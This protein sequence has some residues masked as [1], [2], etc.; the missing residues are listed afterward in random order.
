MIFKK[1]YLLHRPQ[2]N[3]VLHKMCVFFVNHTA[4][5]ILYDKNKNAC[6]SI[7]SS[8]FHIKIFKAHVIQPHTQTTIIIKYFNSFFR[9]YSIFDKIFGFFFFIISIEYF[10]YHLNILLIFIINTPESIDLDGH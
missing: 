3:R 10:F 9:M 5:N 7:I 4:Q 2:I 6:L 1:N 8:Q